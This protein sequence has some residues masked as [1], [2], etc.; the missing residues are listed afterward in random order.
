M[1]N[2]KTWAFV[3]LFMLSGM[4][5]AVPVWAAGTPAR[6]LILRMEKLVKMGVMYGHQDD[7]FY[8]LG[9]AYE[10]GRSDT[11]ELVGDYPAVM[12]FEL[13][14]I[15][16]GDEKNLDSV[17]F[18]LMR[19]E[20]VEHHK[21]GGIV[22]ISW[23]PRNPLLG[24]TAWIE[25]D[26]KAYSQA[27]QALHE[28]GRDD[29]AL[30]LTDPRCTVGSVLPGGR[31]FALFQTWLQRLTAF[32]ASL[33]DE[34]GQPIPF[35]FRPWHENN[36]NWFWWGQNLCSDAEYHAL[37]DM[38]QDFVSQT[39]PNNIVW[40]F[41]PGMTGSWTRDA[42]LKR[43]PGDDRVDL[44]GVDAY[45]YGTREAYTQ[46]L[47]TD[48]DLLQAI[49]RERGKLLAITECGYTNQPD[50][51]WWSEVLR[52]IVE[53]Y[54]IC[55]FLPWR[56]AEHEHFGPSPKAKTA[57]DFKA[58]AKDKRLLFAKEIKRIEGCE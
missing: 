18:Q 24:T 32:L 56:N 13:G 10:E 28:V 23:H 34:K 58:W 42:W 38:T 49:C 2:I 55:Y 46:T 48:L 11:R 57:E 41:S 39:L 7:P 54:P 20:I 40:S 53:K 1:R 3:G 44:I 26:V 45:Q 14:G 50:P 52:P 27:V 33:Q 30:Q 47:S 9:W 8:G 16:R 21:R 29:L 51:T 4:L 22:T 6:Q 5:S 15:E 37:W 36:G 19:K 31:A 25:G 35:I 43:Y 17:P 12:G